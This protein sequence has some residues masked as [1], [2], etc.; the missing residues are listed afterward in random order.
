MS[1]ALDKRIPL[2]YAGI[3]P[4]KEKNA[5]S[6]LVMEGIVDNENKKAA[7]MK[8]AIEAKELA[9]APYSRFSVG[10]AVMCDDGTFYTGC[11]IENASYPCGI[12]AERTAVSKAVSEGKRKFRMIA[13][14]GSSAE[15]CTPCGICRQF[16]YEFAPEMVVLCGDK[17]GAFDEIALSELL[18]RG[19]GASSL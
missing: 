2:R 17:D 9:Y 12:C 7:L 6:A 4:K 8:A 1:L 11:N 5:L 16:L 3:K 18:P 19:F 10:A 13:V 15:K 14:T